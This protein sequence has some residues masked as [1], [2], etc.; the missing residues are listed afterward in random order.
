MYVCIIADEIDGDL[1]CRLL[2]R[3]GDR[4]RTETW[5]PSREISRNAT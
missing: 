4:M 1:V 2:P 5:R 3:S